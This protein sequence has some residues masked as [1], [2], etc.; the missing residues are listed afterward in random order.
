MNS[1]E[2]NKPRVPCR[3]GKCE[4]YGRKQVKCSVCIGKMRILRK[5]TS[6]MFRVKQEISNRTEGIRPE[7]PSEMRKCKTDGRTVLSS[8]NSRFPNPD[9]THISLCM[10]DEGG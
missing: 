10:T 4:F 7:V 6:L 3:L 5:I 9:G 2:E 8:V 1:T